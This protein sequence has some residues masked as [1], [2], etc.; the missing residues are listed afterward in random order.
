MTQAEL[1]KRIGLS[2][3]AIRHFE[4]TG[5]T[6]AFPAKVALCALMECPP[7][8]IFDSDELTVAREV[9]RLFVV[10]EEAGGA[11]A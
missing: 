3:D 5:K 1:G 9:H 2:G 11:A 10:N 7:D 8:W 4:K 6:I